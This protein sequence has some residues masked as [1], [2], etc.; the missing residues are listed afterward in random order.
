MTFAISRGERKKITRRLEQFWGKSKLSLNKVNLWQWF[1]K[2]V[3]DGKTGK[4]SYGTG[5]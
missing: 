5:L 4:T 3:K 2:K 1:L